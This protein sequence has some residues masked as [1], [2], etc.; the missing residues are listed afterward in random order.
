MPDCNGNSTTVVNQGYCDIDMID[1]SYYS[2]F[3]LTELNYGTYIVAKFKATNS[4]GTSLA[5]SPSTAP[6]NSVVVITRPRENPT[7][8]ED[9]GVSK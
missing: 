4:K 2:G 8:V 9:T 3:S 1:F 7:V 6:I 5:Y